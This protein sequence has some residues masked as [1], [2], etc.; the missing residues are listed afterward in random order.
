MD[1]SHPL[2]AGGRPDPL[3]SLGRRHAAQAL[4]ASDGAEAPA[5]GAGE[6]AKPQR[7]QRG[8]SAAR[9]ARLVACISVF[10]HPRL[11]PLSEHEGSLSSRGG[12]AAGG[13]SRPHQSGGAL[14]LH[15]VFYPRRGKALGPHERGPLRARPQRR[16][17]QDHLRRLWQHQAFQRGE[18]AD[19]ARRGRGG[20]R[21]QPR[22]RVCQPPLFQLP[23]P[24]Q[25][26]GH[27]RRDRLHRRREHCRR[28]RE[29]H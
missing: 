28:V 29:P 22:A 16:G 4:T 2:C 7:A 26:H 9:A 6:P 24:P 18:P 5:G 20:H 25:D 12:A 10:E 19:A 13:Y 23:R 3:P 8:P 17:G 11:L 1:H 15:G 14:H 27:R 21:L